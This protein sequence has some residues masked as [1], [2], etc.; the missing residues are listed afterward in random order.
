MQKI[1]YLQ[2][3][4]YRLI[5]A[6]LFSFATIL[7]SI[8]CNPC[9][10][11]PQSEKIVIKEIKCNCDT[12]AEG[13]SDTVFWAVPCDTIKD[14]V[15]FKMGT[16]NTKGEVT[17]KGGKTQGYFIAKQKEIKVPAKIV[18]EYVY[19]SKP[20]YCDKSHLKLWH[21]S[22][23]CISLLLNIIFIYFKLKK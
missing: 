7:L 13:W 22:A 6:L 12:F 8:S 2:K 10:R 3:H 14:T 1:N 21:I 23:F 4:P 5:F 15:I 11:C 9:K 20:V 16:D 18:K 17:V 19:E